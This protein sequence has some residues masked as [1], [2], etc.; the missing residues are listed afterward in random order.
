MR[1]SLLVL[2]KTLFAISLIIVSI[3]LVLVVWAGIHI[4][5]HS[6]Y[7]LKRISTG[8]SLKQRKPLVLVH[9]LNRSGR[10][11]M[12]ADD[13]HGNPIQETMSMVDF[14]RKN[15]YPNIY[16]DTFEDTRNTSLLKNARTLKKWIGI[17][18]KRFNASK[19]DIITHSMGALVARAYIQ[20]MDRD[21]GTPSERIRYNDDVS[22]LIMIAAPHLGSP[23]ADPFA[24]ILKWYAPRTLRA[25]GGPDLRYLNARP[26]PCSVRYGS[27]LLSAKSGNSREGF[28]V[29]RVIRFILAYAR[30]R[31]GDG[32]IGLLSQDLLNAVEQ[33]I[34]PSNLFSTHIIQSEER[35]RHRDASLSPSVQRQVLKILNEKEQRPPKDEISYG[36]LYNNSS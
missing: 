13:G 25:G 19:V 24:F 5:Q 26:L 12:V 23:L 30:P 7:P 29:W 28:S 33:G 17:T 2:F 16:V 15:G 21:D 1:R 6:R 20:E 11:W 9:G 31:D 3:A 14:L 22:R 4:A 10:M 35:I 18:K 36:G 27:I 32:T 34:C 8:K